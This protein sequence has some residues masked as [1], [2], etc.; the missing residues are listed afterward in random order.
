MIRAETKNKGF[1]RILG[2]ILENVGEGE[3][4]TNALR[5]HPLAFNE[6]YVSLVEVGEVGEYTGRLGPALQELADIMAQAHEAKQEA[7]KTM[8]MPLFL[9]G[10][11]ALMLG[12][13]AF[14]AF[15]PLLKTF[16]KMGVV[17]PLPTRIL[18][19]TVAAVVLY[20]IQLGVG[21]F[22]FIA[23][24]KVMGRYPSSKY[25]LDRGKGMIPL[26]GGMIISNEMGRFSRVMATLLSAGVDL[27]SSLRLAKST[28]NNEDLKRAWEAADESLMS[29]HRMAEV[30]G[31]HKIIPSLFRELVSI[32]EESNTLPKTMTELADSY[33]K[34]FQSKISGILAVVEPVSQI[35]VGGVVLMMMLSII[36]PIL[37]AADKLGG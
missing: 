9:V 37:G 27:P 14:V 25:L 33:Q 36:K 8:M 1:R 12:F 30:F 4:F 24:Y 6:V 2:E 11:S 31:D 10:I 15:P 17:I 35:S 23:I 34:E 29:G 22:A 32:G 21:L 13:M 28:S 5:Q 16:N 19:G 26:V 20:K 7:M 18:T 3:S